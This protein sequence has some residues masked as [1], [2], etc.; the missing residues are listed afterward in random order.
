MRKLALILT[1]IVLPH[2][3]ISQVEPYDIMITE[4]MI[5]P[6]PVVGLPN[7]EWI[8][9]YNN[10]NATID[11][12]DL[13]YSSGVTRYK[14]PAY[15]LAP[16]A[17]VM[18]CDDSDIAELSPFGPTIEL[19]VFP[20]LTNGG[21]V[22]RLE[23]T[24]G[25]L[26]HEVTYEKSWY[27]DTSKDEGGYTLEL[28]NPNDPCLAG[29]NWIA[30]NSETGATP[31]AQNSTWMP[32]NPNS[33]ILATAVNP[34]SSSEIEIQF[35]RLPS[36]NLS[37]M[38]FSLSSGVAFL[39]VMADED[40]PRK[41]ILVAADALELGTVYTLTI[42]G[43]IEDCLGGS[44][45]TP[46]TFDFVLPEPFG[47]GDLLINEILFNPIGSESDYVE[48]YNNSN[49]FIDVSQL[50]IGN[51]DPDGSGSDRSIGTTRLVEPGE[52]LLLTEDKTG[53]IQRY[54]SAIDSKILEIDLPSFNNSDG[55]VTIFLEE[56][57]GRII[58]D[59][60]N[61]DES[62]HNE[63]IDDEEGVALERVAFSVLGTERSNWKSGAASFGYGTPT[64]PNS[65]A[66]IFAVESPEPVFLQNKTFFPENQIDG[67]LL[68]S[69]VL[70]RSDYLGTVD[71]FDS[72]GRYIRQI[73]NNQLIGRNDL[74]TWDGR[75]ASGTLKNAGVYII[76]VRMF[77]SDG[78]IITKK[79]PCVL[80]RAI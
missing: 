57:G 72:A 79:L 11:L 76:V 21:D 59:E 22:A 55:N 78:D 41:V 4:M 66:I 14:L 18:V 69:F 1:L 44:S 43:N 10:T 36:S 48:L 53:L 38:D 16:G 32:S 31:A 45:G 6:N 64:L 30:S 37:T 50:M 20:S 80:S 74:Y 3:V 15:D 5:D 42:D 54:P 12:E 7:F 63:F 71:I 39:D 26:I 46:Q 49:K 73:A 23:N 8:E 65:Q 24:N 47:M 33:G 56:S 68:I 67:E 61:Y 62:M 58:V 25:D 77:S 75:D 40:D 60:M 27:G 70:N 35:D 9:L 19:R 28:I 51:L 13:R 2:L 29:S 34:I 17:Y 52:Y